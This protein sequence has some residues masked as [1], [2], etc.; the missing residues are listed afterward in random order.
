MLLK[1]AFPSILLAA[2]AA[3]C[4]CAQTVAADAAADR[5]LRHQSADWLTVESHLPDS[6]TGSPLALQ[7]A[8]DVLRAR[9]LPEDALDYYRFALVRGGSPTVLMNRIGV[10]ELELRRPAAAQVAFKTVLALDSHNAE[11]WNNLGAAEYMMGDFKSALT[12]YRKAVK[13]DK[14]AAVFHSNLGTA[15]FERQDYEGARHQFSMAIKL[16][17]LVFQHSSW[18]G[19]QAHVM[20]AS[21]R[22]RFCFEMAQL[23]A[24]NHN[25]AEVLLW[26]AR[27]TEAGFDVKGELKQSRELAPYLHDV[28]VALIL[29]NAKT[30]RAGQLAAT[31]VP[32]LPADAQLRD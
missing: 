24:E 12:D 32:A 7:T 3:T 6:R 9:R 18:A 2:F 16:D 15:L 23:A 30:M 25:D 27:A 26:L 4:A 22:G 1:L 5:A 31:A 19:L 13:L 14:K 20:S 8:A 11:S 29:S 28:R 10:T 17:P 21:D